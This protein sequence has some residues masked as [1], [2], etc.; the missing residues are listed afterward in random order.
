[1]I[2]LE[3]INIEKAY[4]VDEIATLLNYSQKTILRMINDIENPLP[5]I[6]HK[7]QFRVIGANLKEYLTKHENKPWE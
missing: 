6:R 7:K 2:N 1:M 4:R 5:A 3:H